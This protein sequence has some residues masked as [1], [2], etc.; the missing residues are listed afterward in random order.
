MQNRT[1]ISSSRPA[2]T[3]I[4][5]MVAVSIFAIVMVIAA[6]TLLSLVAVNERAQSIHSVMNNLDAALETMSRNIRTGSFYHCGT[7]NPISG[8]QDCA[9]NGDTYLAFMPSGANP[10]DITDRV[11]Y[12]YDGKSLERCS[13]NCDSQPAYV[14]ITAPEVVIDSFKFY[15]RNSVTPACPASGAQPQV[16]I[17][18]H[19]YAKVPGGTT[20]FRI[21]TGVTQR[22]LSVC[23]SS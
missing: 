21:Q 22:T 15:V 19:G 18:I 16:L 8:T 7:S 5:M 2:F 20:T 14:P 9:Q 10:N 13:A 4:E 6:G 11:A 17:S 12:Y 23:L 3:L 1:S